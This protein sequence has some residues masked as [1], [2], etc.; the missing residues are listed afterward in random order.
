MATVTDQQ[1]IQQEEEELEEIE[2]E[3]FANL[4]EFL[5]GQIVD[6]CVSE[7]CPENKKPSMFFRLLQRKHPNITD[8]IQEC[9]TGVCK[10][11]EENEQRLKSEIKVAAD[12]LTEALKK[13]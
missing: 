9:L 3:V 11:F 6:I 13:L 12:N 5:I 8:K 4:M 2:N 7:V 10:I 1:P